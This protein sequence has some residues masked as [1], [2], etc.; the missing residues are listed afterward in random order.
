MTRAILAAAAAASLAAATARAAA[1]S[2]S[3]TA[4]SSATYRVDAPRSLQVKKGEKASAR[5]AIVPRADSHVS[6]DAPVS[7]AVSA[8]PSIEVPQAKLGRPD[9]RETAQKGV[10]FDIPFVARSAGPGAVDANLVFFICTEKL[11]ERHKEHVRLAVL[12]E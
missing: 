5:I 10:A 8:T 7:V 12:A 3:P 11:C 2:A 4:P 9:A 1:D 6:P